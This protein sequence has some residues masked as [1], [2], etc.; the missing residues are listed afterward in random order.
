M[1]IRAIVPPSVATW[2]WTDQLG[3]FPSPTAGLISDFSSYGLAP[4]LSVKPDI[5]APGGDI[6]STYPIE[7]GSFAS[8]S[9]TSMASPHVAGAVALMLEAHPLI[10]PVTMR[11]LLQ[12][13]ADPHLWNLAPQYGIY[14]HV[15]RQGAGMLDIDDAILAHDELVIM[16]GKLELGEGADGPSTHTLTVKNNSNETKILYLDWVPAISAHG[17]ID[18]ENDFYWGGEEVSFSKDMLRLPRGHV[19]TVQVTITPPEADVD[20]P[21]DALYNGWIEFYEA[22]DGQEPGNGNMPVYRVPYAGFVGD[23]QDIVHLNNPYDFP[24]VA[25]LDGGY[26][27]GIDP[28]HVFTLES[29][30]YP[31]L[32]Y[33]LDHQSPRFIVEVVNATTGRRAYP[34]F[35]KI[36][37]WDYHGR[38]ST[39]DSFWAEP[40]DGTRMVWNRI[41]DVPDG[42]YQMRVRVLKALGDP[43]N[44]DD[45]EIW[46]SPMFFIDRPNFRFH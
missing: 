34:I 23:F 46:T 39:T 13:T 4:D 19:T 9:G 41:A 37:N 30:D 44:P 22:V 2:T 16:P 29:G 11:D 38:S 15:Y 21:W 5:G 6:Y 14:D 26:F 17:I 20:M 36:W 33:H 32:L 3:S 42:A 18:V 45:W 35:S 1:A 25:Y 27:Y 43:L 28:G 31:Y 40:W 8:L 12:N 10:L 7:Q 24:W